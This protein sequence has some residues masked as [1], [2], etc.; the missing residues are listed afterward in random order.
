MERRLLLQVNPGARE[1]ANEAGVALLEVLAAIFVMGVGLLALLTLF[2]LGA[3]EMAQAIK[4]DR[5]AAVAD[6][7]AALAVEGQDLIKR[8]ASFVTASLAAGSAVFAGGHPVARGTRA[9]RASRRSTSRSS[10]WS[11]KMPSRPNRPA[12]TW[13]PCW[14]RSNESG[15]AFTR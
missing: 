7:A 6:N 15:A 3:L 10:S 4:D 9:V 13:A 5:T 2:P 8:T 14:R 11:F 12:A 1:C